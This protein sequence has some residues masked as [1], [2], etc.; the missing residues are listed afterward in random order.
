MVASAEKT[1]DLNVDLVKEMKDMKMEFANLMKPALKDMTS[2]IED[3][4]NSLSTQNKDMKQDLSHEIQQIQSEVTKNGSG[5]RK[6]A[7]ELAQLQALAIKNEKSIAT[8]REQID[9]MQKKLTYMED[10]SRRS[11]LKLINFEVQRRGEM[12]KEILL[13]FN[14]FLPQHLVEQ[15][16][17]RVHFVDNSK[18]GLLRPI[19][20]R[21]ASYANKELF[22]SAIRAKPELLKRGDKTVQVYQDISKESFEWR[23]M[24]RPVTIALMKNN[25]KYNWGYTVFLK[26][27]K[28]PTLHRIYSLEEGEQLLKAWNIQVEKTTSPR[29][30]AGTSL[31]SSDN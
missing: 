1:P 22:M 20:V 25:L 21:F 29:S 13:W 5:I 31:A 30:A 4:F 15:D 19:L 9:S 2:I 12:K 27:W 18:S 7:D 14:S 26:V 8:Q 10:Y 28:H 3:W 24:M 11:N 23:K 17:E 6:L 16:I